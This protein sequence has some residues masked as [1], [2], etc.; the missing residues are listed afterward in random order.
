[1]LGAM[2]LSRFIRASAGVWAAV[3]V[4]AAG[5]GCTNVAL[6]DPVEIPAQADKVAFTGQVCTDNPA[7][8]S[9]PLRVVFVVDSSAQV[10]AGLD[11]G[12][13]ATL[14][15][16]RMDSLR[17]VVASLRS[18]DTSFALVRNGGESL[19]Q[20]EGGFTSNATEVAEAAGAL[21]VAVPCT[22][23][24]C[25][26]TGQ[27]LS[28]ASSLITGDL[29]STARGPRS[30]TKYVIVFVQNGPTDDIVL[31]G[32]VTPDCDVACVL[33]ERVAQLREQVVDNGGADLQ[34]HAI[35]LASLSS[36]DTERAS[37]RNE[38]QRMA[39]AGA[40]EYQPCAPATKPAASS[41]PAAAPRTSRSRPSTST[42]PATCS[43]RR[44]SS[45]PT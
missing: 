13:V 10:I 39:F 21:T 3:A 40:G 30:R 36:D 18:R 44:A 14:Q 43:S 17:D 26:R 32:A 41:S 6:Y 29:L 4:V 28:I 8:R 22:A 5:A 34:V 33:Q 35:D 25:R 38:L 16:R 42:A 20:P 12:D 45:S 11:G 7:E 19:L 23:D 2:V 27:A 31:D 1:M 24:G 37:A 9:F 15:A